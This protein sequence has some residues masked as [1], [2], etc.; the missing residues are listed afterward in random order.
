MHR[1]ITYYST[2]VVSTRDVSTP[3]ILKW[4][5]SENSS[6]GKW[7]TYRFQ[8]NRTVV[9][10]SAPKASDNRNQP[11]QMVRNRGSVLVAS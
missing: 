11:T 4:A 1:E 6:S 3:D 10:V 9:Q 2:K 8:A 5:L 7:E